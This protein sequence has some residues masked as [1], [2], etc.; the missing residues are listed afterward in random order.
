MQSIPYALFAKHYYFDDGI[1]P[2]ATD[3][4]ISRL[5][6]RGFLLGDAER[7]VAPGKRFV[8]VTRNNKDA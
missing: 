7:G 1:E 2:V 4:P 3:R 8:Y 5:G 6:F